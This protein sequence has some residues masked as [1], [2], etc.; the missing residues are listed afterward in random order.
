METNQTWIDLSQ[1]IA[2]SPGLSV[3]IGATDTGKTTLAKFLIKEW[4]R[5]GFK[6]AFV[7]GDMGQSTLG[8]P[9]ALGM[10]V[11]DTSNLNFE[12]SQF[13]KDISLYFIGSYS[14][15][16]Y[17][18]QTVVGV[19][20]LVRKAESHKPD[21]ILVDTTGLVFGGVG[22]HLKYRKLQLL[23]PKHVL[24]IQKSGELEHLKNLIK[25]DGL[26][27][28]DLVQSSHI[29][30][31]SPEVRRNHRIQRLKEYF[32][33][34]KVCKL[35]FPKTIIW[36]SD[37]FSGMRLTD[38]ELHFCS[39]ILEG[40]ILYGEKGG[41]T[42]F[43]LKKDFIFLKHQE[44]IK[45]KYN[46][47]NLLI[48]NNWGFTNRLVAMYDT[49]GEILTIGILKRVDFEHKV[50]NVLGN[51]EKLETIECMEIGKETIDDVSAKSE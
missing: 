37:Y 44:T 27:I 24:I 9:G 6:V 43:L 3:I 25:K 1:K 5:Q 20:E 42:L 49:I 8:P 4:T 34:S 41:R 38:E 12:N 33:G 16:G 30:I 14:P 13:T 39:Q 35:N 40:R 48:T 47:T 32:K 50:I 18:L 26:T 36:G 11:F 19:N 17:L 10:R 29:K 28:H 23:Q 45:A 7:D 46:V 22:E 31:R 2:E 15:V 51:L 21:I